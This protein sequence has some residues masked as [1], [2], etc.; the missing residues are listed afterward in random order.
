MVG[1]CDLV[2]TGIAPVSKKTA[3]KDN[4]IQ[5]FFL[6]FTQKFIDIHVP[7]ISYEVFSQRKNTNK[8]RV[9]IFLKFSEILETFIKANFSFPFSWKL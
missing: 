5:I 7:F 6:F 4:K 3:V 9:L 1:F 2:G 8:Q